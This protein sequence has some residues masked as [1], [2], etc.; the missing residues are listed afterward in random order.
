MLSQFDSNGE[1]SNIVFGIGIDC[2][3]KGG[4]VGNSDVGGDEECGGVGNTCVGCNDGCG[5]ESVR[6]G[7]DGSENVFRGD[8]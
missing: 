7:A 5:G 3:G 8:G 2:T 6:S 4:G 1:R